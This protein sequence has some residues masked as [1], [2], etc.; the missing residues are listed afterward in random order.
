MNMIEVSENKA[1]KKVFVEFSKCYFYVILCGV[2]I[3][4]LAIGHK[5]C[6]FKPGQRRWIFK[7][8]KRLQHAFLRRGNKD[9]GP[10]L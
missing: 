4:V 6:R 3:S 7:G 1:L 2:M 10:I 5:V 9:V 8:N